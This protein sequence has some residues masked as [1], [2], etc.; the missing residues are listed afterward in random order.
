MYGSI[1]VTGQFLGRPSDYVELGLLN[2]TG[3]AVIVDRPDP[4]FVMPPDQSAHQVLMKA[5][6]AVPP[7]TYT[8]VFRVNGA[9]AKQAF[10][11]NMV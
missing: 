3:V 2:N 7:G 4:A 5:A 1:K 11:L 8:A 10:L 6:D 9:Q